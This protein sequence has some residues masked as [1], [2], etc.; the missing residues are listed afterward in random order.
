MLKLHYVSS[1][2]HVRCPGNDTPPTSSQSKTWYIFA[3]QEVQLCLCKSFLLLEYAILY[4]YMPNWGSSE[5]AHF[6]VYSGRWIAPIVLWVVI[7]SL[8]YYYI[9]VEYKSLHLGISTSRLDSQAVL[10]HIQFKLFLRIT[11][12]PSRSQLANDADGQMYIPR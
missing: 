3:L 8:D 5:F 11:N 4:A 6:A 7:A 9:K 10:L 1:V 2:I 12:N